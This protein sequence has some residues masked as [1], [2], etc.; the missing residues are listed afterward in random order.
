MCSYL[1]FKININCWRYFFVESLNI[2][3]PI[4]TA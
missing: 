1:F 2:N 4:R 3:Y